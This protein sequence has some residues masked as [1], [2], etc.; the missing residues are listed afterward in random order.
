[1]ILNLKILDK[2]RIVF[3]IMT[4]LF[5][6]SAEA[7]KKTA[8]A[9][10][11]GDIT[12]GGKKLS[13]AQIQV[14]VNGSVIQTLP[15]KEN[16]SWTVTLDLGKEYI[17]TYSCPGYVSKSVEVNTIVPPDAAD[18]GYVN[19]FDM[20]LPEDIQGLS[21]SDP[22]NKSIARWKYSQAVEDFD[23]DPE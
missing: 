10:F 19:K 1:M 21:K 18:I 2:V 17:I 20:D 14:S 16:G 6:F 8:F 13:K 15:A 7:Q 11:F 12:S 9:Q 22:M 23:F 3:L 5:S 4:M